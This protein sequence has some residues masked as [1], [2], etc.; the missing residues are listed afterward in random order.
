MK[1]YSV[2]DSEFRPYGR[3]V[4]GCDFS[5]LISLL[6][7]FSSVISNSIFFNL[8]SV[9]LIANIL[10]WNSLTSSLSTTNSEVAG[11]L[12]VI[13]SNG[14]FKGP[15]QLINFPNTYG[16]GKLITE[17]KIKYGIW[18]ND[19]LEVSYDEE[20]AFRELEGHNLGRFKYMF[21]LW[22]L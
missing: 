7:S 22:F 9:S 2:K 4:D 5:E 18:V 12:S 3:V 14:S 17:S 1:L 15:R 19:S 21:L 16:F 20:E 10:I 11:T 8:S 6:S 13:Y